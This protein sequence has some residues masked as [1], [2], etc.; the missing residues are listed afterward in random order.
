MAITKTVN[1]DVQ[2]NLDESTK[3]VG[4]LKAQLRE[5]QAEVAALSD[6]FGATSKQAV[7]AAKKAAQLK[8]A[9]GD[10]K[11]LTDSFNPDAK[12][13]ALT[14]SLSG[15]AGG[16]SAVT[17]AMGLLGSESEE[18]EQ[19]I[20]KVQSAM[21]IS[22]GIQ[23]VGESID[24]FKQL[25]AVIKSATV[26]Q[27]LNSAATTVAATVQRL[28]TGAVNTTAVSF[29][30]LK[31]AIVSTGIGA[32]VVGLGFL[33]SKLMASSDA[34]KELTDKQKALNQEL[35]YSKELADDNA[36]TIDYNTKIAIASAKQRGASEKEL[37]RIQLDA[38][39]KKGKANAAEYEKIKKSQDNEI[40]LTKEQNKRLQEIREE[41]INL[42]REGNLLAAEFESTSADKRRQQSQ[43][44]ND[45]LLQKQK[46]HNQK[47]KEERQRA[48]E[49]EYK[50]NQDRIRR[51]AEAAM[52]EEAKSFNAIKDAKK[53][54]EDL[55][56]TEQQ[57]AIDEENLAYQLKLENAL[58]FNQSTEELEIQHLNNLNNINLTAQQKQ[59]AD[60]EA[61][62]Q[63][64]IELATKEKEAKLKLMDAVSNG[65]S[66]AAGELG[67][68]TA[69]G[70]AAA[71]AAATIS[72]YTAIAG[73]LQAFSKVPIPGYAIAQ[74]IVT[75]A[76]GLL[77]V[78]KILE[79]K[80]PEGGG[81]GGGSAPSMGGIAAPA[82]PSF[83]VV[84]NAGVNKLAEV[85]SN[86][87]MPPVQA[88]VVAS[89]VTSA[90]SLNRNIVSNATL[91]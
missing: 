29:N 91:G 64:S 15:V 60:D 85:M 46:D 88:Y 61:A 86:K 73:Q 71:V 44:V 54:N 40:N 4:S 77:Q 41:N 67:A 14:N 70:K 39:E 87:G 75:G 5:A 26:F 32:L 84:G 3:S 16:F 6:K 8:D 62:R 25:G 30:A 82:S 7:E 11:T 43:K 80:V 63:A 24:S 10:A 17:G 57:L 28:F 13:A 47:T 51:F 90:Q 66:L 89:N 58:K 2:S 18:V 56:K 22:Q 38:L 72:T 81:S 23:A 52:E 55:L 35:E 33:I 37:L 68:A 59:Y 12:F 21:A 42:Q 1:L 74:A 31:A 53:A 49:E 27:K 48:A 45:D 20:L 76:T 69:E 83:N 19:M 34:T 79:V 9:I 65:L 78:K 50:E 36:K